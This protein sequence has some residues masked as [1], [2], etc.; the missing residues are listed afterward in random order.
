[1]LQV[2]QDI[3]HHIFSGSVN[4]REAIFLFHDGLILPDRNKR[5]KFRFDSE[6]D[7]RELQP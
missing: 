3:K 4:N 2:K 7:S 6:I 1:M 5:I